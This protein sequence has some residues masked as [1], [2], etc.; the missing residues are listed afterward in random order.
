M[1]YPR[2][3]SIVPKRICRKITMRTRWYSSPFSGK[4]KKKKNRSGIY[5]QSHTIFHILAR[6]QRTAFFFRL[7]CPFAIYLR[8][9]IQT[10]FA[11]LL[12][13]CGS[14]TKTANAMNSTIDSKTFQY[15]LCLLSNEHWL[16]RNGRTENIG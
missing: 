14:T 6:L 15:A 1:R 13:N 4:K 16:A 7:F 9:R 5:S 8:Q 2:M 11:F 3:V 10:D 12:R